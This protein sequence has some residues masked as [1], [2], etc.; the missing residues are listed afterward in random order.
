MEAECYSDV[1]EAIK[2]VGT[3]EARFR[4]LPPRV[5]SL[6]KGFR[7]RFPSGEPSA[8][9]EG[10]T[11]RRESIHQR[12]ME[13]GGP[14]WER[15]GEQRA[16]GGTFRVGRK[17]FVFKSCRSPFRP[18]CAS[19]IQSQGAIGFR[20]EVQ[21]QDNSRN[22]CSR[23]WQRTLVRRWIPCRPTCGLPNGSPPRPE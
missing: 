20:R 6:E 19:S 7:P 1:G 17:E 9:G 23:R 4:A 13:G 5:S 2:I 8:K 11:A 3:L 22:V 14:I 12:D 16:C 18:L 10:D 21:T 15:T